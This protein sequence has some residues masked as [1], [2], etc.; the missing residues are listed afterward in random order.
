MHFHDD[1]GDPTDGAV[2]HAE[3]ADLANDLG[4][5]LDN[6]DHRVFAAPEAPAGRTNRA[7]GRSTR[8]TGV[9]P[10]NAK[11]A[12]AP[13]PLRSGHVEVSALADDQTP[14][15]LTLPADHA[16]LPGLLARRGTRLRRVA[17][18]VVLTEPVAA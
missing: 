11:P 3:S 7:T 6:P 14:V 2:D 5:D 18:G 16:A 4:D 12:E 13:R 9:D 15:R 8:G 10:I 1:S 17:S